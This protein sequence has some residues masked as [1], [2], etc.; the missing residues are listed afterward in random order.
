MRT[1]TRIAIASAALTA[2]LALTGGSQAQ[3]G[4]AIDSA[5]RAP[6]ARVS[7]R[8]GHPQFRVG[9]YVPRGYRVYLRPNY[10][11]G[12]TYRDCW[13]PVRRYR[14]TWRVYDRPYVVYNDYSR[15]DGRRYNDRYDRRHD[16]DDRCDHRDHRDRDHDRDRYD[17]RYD[18]DRWND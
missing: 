2:G 9:A 3:A 12:F 16:C 4:I 1:L 14:S 17:D 18:R 5:F 7:V 11:Y 8:I 6:H 15:H 13:I 10:G